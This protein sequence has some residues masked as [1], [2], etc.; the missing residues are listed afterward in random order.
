MGANLVLASGVLGR[1]ELR[2]T[3][4]GTPLL[5]IALVGKRPVKDNFVFTRVDLTFYG[6]LAEAWA[7]SLVEGAAYQASGRL[8]YESWEVDGRKGS[9]LRVVGEELH[10]LEGADVREEEKGPVLYGADNRVFLIGGLTADPELRQTSMKTPIAK[11]QLGF[12]TWDG[13]ASKSH[14]VELEAWGEL[15]EPFKSLK[16]GS[17]VMIEGALKTEVWEDRESKTKRYKRLVEVGKVTALERLNAGAKA[18]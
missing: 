6:K 15:A 1:H 11:A 12:S 9:R 17:Q 7:Q 8:E 18:A 14:Y 2:Y 13:Q 3:P 10:R 16:K 5:E 4:R